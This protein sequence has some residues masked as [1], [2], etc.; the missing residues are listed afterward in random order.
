M[1]F[2]SKCDKFT[3]FNVFQ[4]IWFLQQF[5][6]LCL[7]NQVFDHKW[8]L[9]GPYYKPPLIFRP[10]NG[11]AYVPC[12]FTYFYVLTQINLKLKFVSYFNLKLWVVHNISFFVMLHFINTFWISYLNVINSHISMYSNQFGCF[13]NLSFYAYWM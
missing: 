10:G 8:I 9:W 11:P 7:L 2:V 12:V 3:Y 5:I 13:N 1:N 4:S 6:F